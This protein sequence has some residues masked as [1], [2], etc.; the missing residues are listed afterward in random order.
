MTRIFIRIFRVGTLKA[1][2][3]TSFHHVPAESI[4]DKKKSEKLRQ[5]IEER[6]KAR[7]IDDKLKQI[8][9]KL[10]VIANKAV[11][12]E[13]RTWRAGFERRGQVVDSTQQKAGKRA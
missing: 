6:R 4:T 9:G 1:D 7:K 13:F 3:G 2:D 8:K 12:V 5:K 11:S 10:K